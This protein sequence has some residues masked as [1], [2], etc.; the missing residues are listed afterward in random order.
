MK[1]YIKTDLDMRAVERAVQKDAPNTLRRAGAYV[2]AVAKNSIKQRKNP[3]IASA[4]G[5]PPVSHKNKGNPG[6]KRTILFGVTPSGT[7]VLVGP[8]HVKGGLA[9]VGR[10][11]EFGGKRVIRAIDADK[12]DNGLK[13]GDDGPVTMRHIRKKDSIIR[14]DPHRDPATGRKVVW[15]RLRTKT[16]AEHST[17]L[18]R[19]MSR[20]YA[21]K[22]AVNYPAR[23]YMGPALERSAPKLS[24][25][26]HNSV[27]P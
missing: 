5:S 11:H 21:R 6:F 15:I 9:N 27:K 14:S 3:D 20:K 25:F 19:R 22:I 8:M 4:P 7:S 12:F 23:P 16:Q 17:R 18:Y 13:I 26:W 10:I 1:V 2:R 24:K